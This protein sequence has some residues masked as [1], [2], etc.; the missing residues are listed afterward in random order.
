MLCAILYLENSD[1]ARFADPKKRIENDYV[2]NKAEYPRTVTTVQ[3][4]LLN[5]QPNYNSHINFQSNGVSNQLVFGQ[6]GKTGDKKGG[7]KVKDQRPRR[8][9]DHVTCNDCG[10]KVHYD[11]NNNCPTQSR[12]KEDVEAFRKMK[13]EKFSNKPPGEGDQKALVNVKDAL[14]SLMM[15]SPTEEWGEVPSRGPMFCQTSTQ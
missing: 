1:K 15:V 2:L 8:N 5:Y 9:M 10:E 6:H 4:I 13:Q 12:L 3:S 11:G 7:R 14:C